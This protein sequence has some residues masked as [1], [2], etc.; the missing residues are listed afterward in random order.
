MEEQKLPKESVLKLFEGSRT[1]DF[2]KNLPN[3]EAVSFDPI[4]QEISVKTVSDYGIKIISL[5]I[6]LNSRIFK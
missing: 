6:P 5:S 1:Y 3:W 2:L 4:R